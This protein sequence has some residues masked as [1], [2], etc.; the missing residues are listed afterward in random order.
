M[1]LDSVP[2]EYLREEILQQPKAARAKI[3]KKTELNTISSKVDAGLES[4][5]RLRD[6]IGQ[7]R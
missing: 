5:K 7:S 6:N 1:K 2:E 3:I 4:G